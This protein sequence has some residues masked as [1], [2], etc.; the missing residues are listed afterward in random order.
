MSQ[1]N[2]VNFLTGT[3]GWTEN[4]GRKGLGFSESQWQEMEGGPG[5]PE[6]GCTCFEA[7]AMW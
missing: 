7:C 5:T 6:W 3:E 2:C 1:L 4:N